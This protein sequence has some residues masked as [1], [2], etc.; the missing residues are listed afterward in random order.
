MYLY[1]HIFNIT[2]E[3]ISRSLIGF[4][5]EKQKKV[6]FSVITQKGEREIQRQR[7]RESAQFLA[8]KFGGKTPLSSAIHPL[9]NLKRA[10]SPPDACCPA[11]QGAIPPPLL[12]CSG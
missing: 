9:Q 8:E 10:L 11:T 6:K 3:N 5:C 2:S 4:N 1:M 7:D 12:L